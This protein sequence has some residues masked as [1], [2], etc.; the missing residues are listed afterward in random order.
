MMVQPQPEDRPCPN[1]GTGHLVPHRNAGK[2]QYREY[3]NLLICENCWHK[4]DPQPDGSLVLIRNP[5]HKKGK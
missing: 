2:R 5:R 3:R 1:C 4:Y